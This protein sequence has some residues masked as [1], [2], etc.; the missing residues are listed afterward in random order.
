MPRQMASSGRPACSALSSR[1]SSQASRSA[2]GAP[3]AGCMAAPYRDGST[4]PPPATT[5]PSRSATVAAASAAVPPGG[6]STGRPPPRRTA[7][8]YVRGST[9]AGA[10]QSR[11]LAESL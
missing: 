6:S 11:H 5:R 1:A 9:A 4:S 3:V 8:T 10:D 7:S 2:S